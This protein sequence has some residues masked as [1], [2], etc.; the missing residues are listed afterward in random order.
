[1]RTLFIAL[2]S[3]LLPALAQAYPAKVVG[4][5]DGDTITVLDEAKTQHKIRLSAIDAPEMGQP[6]GQDSR[7]AMAALVAGRQVEVQPVDTD[8]YGRTVAVILVDH[9]NV[10]RAMVRQ[11][12]AWAYRKYLNDPML[13]QLEQEARSAKRGLWSLQADQIMAP[14][15]WRHG[16][17]VSANVAQVAPAPAVGAGQFSCTTKRICRQIGSCGEAQFY[18]TQCG[19]TRLDS[20]HDGVPCEQVC[21]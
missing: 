16:G 6:Y 20:D 10:N 4:V 14:W 1:M 18:L 9:E 2:A 8:R 3:I 13:M 21:R 12:A 17:K 5:H 7:Q 15:D 11:G 19:Q